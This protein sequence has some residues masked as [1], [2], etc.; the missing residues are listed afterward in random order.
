VILLSTVA[1]A[2]APVGE[3]KPTADPAWMLGGYAFA[4]AGAILG[5]FLFRA[6][7]PKPF[8]PGPNISTF[9]MLYIL[10]QALERLLEPL[11]AFLDGAT[12]RA[13]KVGARN[14]AMIA[15][16]AAGPSPSTADLDAVRLAQK[17]VDQLRR[18]KAV[19]LWGVA[20]FLAMLV[21]GWLGVFLLHLMGVHEGGHMV[22]ILVTGLVIGSGTKP[23]HDL[24]SNIQKSKE[25]KEDAAT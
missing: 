5:W 12:K 24:I 9:A 18:N 11:S 19:V 8:T 10:T 25:N 1:A 16:V 6:F 22:D 7:D 20:T 4:V 15:A 14:S 21:S 17:E 3:E 23:L 13:Q 2:A